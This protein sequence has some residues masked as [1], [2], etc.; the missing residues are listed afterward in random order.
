MTAISGVVRCHALR[1]FA[2][3]WPLKRFAFSAKFRR[4][5]LACIRI[6]LL[7]W[8]H[9][10]RLAA[11]LVPSQA[12]KILFL[13]KADERIILLQEHMLSSVRHLP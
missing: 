4:I 10:E 12:W 13:Q 6:V 3:M 8:Y 9:M 1:S 5:R 11:E 7:R 2:G